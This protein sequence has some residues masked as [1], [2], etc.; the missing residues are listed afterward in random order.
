MKPFALRRYLR[1]LS[2]R[3][4]EQSKPWIAWNT[5]NLLPMD[6]G[7]P[8][9]RKLR[10]GGRGPP[11]ECGYPFGISRKTRE[12]S[13]VPTI[14]CCIAR[15]LRRAATFELLLLNWEGLAIEWLP[16]C[17]ARSPFWG[18]GSRLDALYRSFH[19]SSRRFQ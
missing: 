11:A 17:T 4:L 7:G 8:N 2:T 5:L 1:F 10:V 14:K 9:R 6:L 18:G 13:L 19:A 16:V 3:P 12:L 15:D